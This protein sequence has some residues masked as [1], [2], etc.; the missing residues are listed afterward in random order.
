MRRL[1]SFLTFILLAV[2]LTVSPASAQTAEPPVVRAV[3]F[4]KAGCGSCEK[5][6][7]R[8]LPPI[9]QKHGTQF[10]LRLVEIV[11]MQDVD[12][13]YALAV[14]YDIPHEQ[15]GVPFLIIDEQVLIGT[16]QISDELPDLIEQYLARGGVDWPDN[17]ILAA[18]LPASP[19][20]SN[21]T[22]SPPAAAATPLPADTAPAVPAHIQSNG[23]TFAIVIMVGMGM[24]LLYSL[25]AFALGK[26]FQLPAWS[27]WLI[28]ALIVIGVGVAAYLAYVETQSVEAV[29]GPVG[30]CNTVQQSRYATLFGFLPVGVLG[31]L[32]YLGLLAAWLV[33]RF[34]PRFEK[35]AAIGFWGMGFFGTLF[36]LYLTYLEPF[37]IKAV[38]LWCLSSAVIMMLLLLLGTPP[39][40]VQFAISDENE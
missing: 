27:D 1:A 4:W 21:P 23:F 9:Q 15:V 6:L 29:C 16:R 24:A 5:T 37:V 2:S 35:L 10:E 18:Y 32:G 40:V 12:T 19:P 3:I 8:I 22:P 38:C 14:S 17:P 34:V 36:S 30:D 11:T 25:I 26:T 7:Y 13:L 28:P 31:L 33:R 39:A 20:A